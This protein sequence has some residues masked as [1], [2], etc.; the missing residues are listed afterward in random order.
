MQTKELIRSRR[1]QTKPLADKKKFS[2]AELKLNNLHQ[3]KAQGESVQRS[4][5]SFTVW[6]NRLAL[7][8]RRERA[9]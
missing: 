2:S 7:K 3:I 6:S 8:H 4:M 1:N 9:T 5:K